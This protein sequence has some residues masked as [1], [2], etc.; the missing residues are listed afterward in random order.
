[1][2]AKAVSAQTVSSPTLLA[3]GAGARAAGLAP[4]AT[5]AGAVGGLRRAGWATIAVFFLGFGGWAWYAPLSSAAIAPG[6]V[7]PDGKRRT[8]QHLEGG[9]VGDILVRDGSRVEAGQPVLVLSD[10]RARSQHGALVEQ[11][12]ILSAVEARL[13]AE[14]RNLPA[15]A[16]PEE[17]L[18]SQDAR[19]REVV[20]LQNEL[21]HTR[22]SARDGQE[23]V[24]R[25][26]IRQLREEIAGHQARIR[27]QDVQL[28]LI[29]EEADAV[30]DLVAKGLERKPRL[31]SL[32]RARAEIEGDRA[33]SRA[34]IARAE[35]AI[36]EAEI[37]I[38]TQTD[39]WRDEVAAELAETRT[40]LATV[41]SEM[42]A[43]ADA[44][45]RTVVRAPVPGLVMDMRVTT[46]GGVLAAGDPI[47]DIVPAEAELVVDAQVSPLDI[48]DV[49]AG[50]PAHVVLSAYKQR[51][52]PRLMG[53]VRDVTADRLTDP[54][55][56]QPYFLARVV[57]PREALASVGH[58]VEMAPG[59][60]AEVLIET[61]ER[62]LLDYLV[63]PF[64]ESIRRSFRE[65]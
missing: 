40:K 48:D 28:A 41:E 44:L 56:G 24:I 58:G 21:F 2:S 49:H 11:R 5:A 17:L 54:R 7:A 62:T 18:G 16:F 55:T 13:D 34:Q 6:V 10:I 60:P 19:V 25:Q 38:L 57:V 3:P 14:Q 51:N 45:A 9:I 20:A 32:E 42:S 63:Q 31:L 22:R 64:I 37:Q 1:V 30:R 36:G 50:L 23:K 47:L 59:M 65:G 53:T 12:R 29:A 27:S 43:T 26:R 39:K 15:P 8:V 46:T 33:E 52:L 35:Q 61:G 4:A